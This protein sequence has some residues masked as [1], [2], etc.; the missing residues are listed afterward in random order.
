MSE[1]THPNVF[2]TLRYKDA[3]AALEWLVRAFGFEEKAV[4]R[5]EDGAIQHA[6]LRLGTGMIV[7]GQHRQGWMGQQAARLVRFPP[8]HLR[9]R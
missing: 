6:E 3:S 1:G 7:F 9:C 8:E 2:P 5:G 4:Y